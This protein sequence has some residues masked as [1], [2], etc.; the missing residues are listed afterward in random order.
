MSSRMYML[1]INSYFACNNTSSKSCPLC[2]LLLRSFKQSKACC[3][4]ALGP[5]T[6]GRLKPVKWNWQSGN[7]LWISWSRRSVFFFDSGPLK[8]GIWFPGHSLVTVAWTLF[9][10][11]NTT[12]TWSQAHINTRHTQIMWYR[13]LTWLG[14]HVSPP[15]S[16]FESP[17]LS[18]SYQLFVKCSWW[19]PEHLQWH[20]VRFF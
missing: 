3:R 6:M 8:I 17:H 7:M 14:K 12:Q 15:L 20:E 5:N 19:S 4:I 10:L 18:V 11:I 9:R 13:F 1:A 16:V 2:T